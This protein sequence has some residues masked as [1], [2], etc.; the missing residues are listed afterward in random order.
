MVVD[1][2]FDK[3]L[4][5][6]DGHVMR[7]H[8]VTVERKTSKVRLREGSSNVVSVRPRG[9]RATIGIQWSLCIATG[10]LR[11]GC[12]RWYLCLTDSAIG[13]TLN[14]VLFE[15]FLSST[16]NPME[17]S[18][19]RNWMY[20]R[21]DESR[22]ITIQFQ[23]GIERFISFALEHKRISA[24]KLRCPCR[25]CK[26][27]EFHNPD[28]LRVHLCKY[29]FMPDYYCWTS[30]GESHSKH[31]PLVDRHSYYG[32]SGQRHNYDHYEQLV[33]DAAGP[34]LGAHL[35]VYTEE[36]QPLMAEDPNPEASQFFNMLQASQ[37]PLWDGCETHT[38]LSACLTALSL[39]TDYRMTEGC[40]NQWMK[41]VGDVLP[42]GHSMPKD[43][44]NA[45]KSV[46]NLGLGGEK[47]HCCRNGC[48]LFYKEYAQLNTCKFCKEDR[49]TDVM[50]DGKVKAKPLKKMWYFPLVPRLQRLYSSEQTASQMRWHREHERNINSLT[51]P[52]DAEAWL[53]FDEKNNDFAQDPRN[54]RIGLC[55]D[56][57]APF[58][59]TGRTYS[60]W[61][62]IITPYNLPPWMCMRRE[63]LFLSCII[64]GPSNPKRNIDVYLR[65]LIDELKMLWTCGVL[66]YDVSLKQNL[67]MRAA[68]MWTIND[69]PAYGMLSGWQTMGKLACP[70]CMDKCK[71]FSLQ[72]S[73]KVS[74]FDC[75]R[76]FLPL[77]HPYRKNKHAFT[78]GRVE[79]SNIPIR[80]SGE[81]VWQRVRNLM[82][83]EENANFV[84]DEEY[85]QSHH[86]TKRS[87]FWELPYWKDQ[88]LRHNL[89]VMH[90][91]RNVFLNILYTMMDTKGKTKD[92]YNA[93]KD[94]ENH[95]NRSVLH[96]LV[97]PNG[98]VS[99]PKA[100]YT[101]NK[102]QKTELLQ[103][104][105]DLKFPDGYASKMSRCVDMREAKLFG[106]KSHDCHV[107]FQRLLP[108]AFKA[109]PK[110][111]WN[112]LIELGVYFRDICASEL[113]V[114]KLQ[115]MEV[116]VP[117]MLC[118][119]E[120]FFPPSFFDS[121]EHLPIH[122]A[123]EVR[124]GGP[125]QYRWMYPFERFIRTTKQKIGNTNHVEGSIAE[126]YLLEE[127]STFAS[128]YY[129]PEFLTRRTRVPRNDHGCGTTEGA[130][131]QKS[132]F[133]YPG[134]SIGRKSQTTLNSID[135]KTAILYTLLNCSEVVPYLEMFYNLERQQ[136]PLITDTQLDHK[137]T[138]EFPDW[139]SRKIKLNC[140]ALQDVVWSLAWGPSQ[141]VTRYPKYIIN[142]YK[143]A[144]KSS[145]Q[146]MATTNYGVCVRGSQLESLEVDYYGVLIDIIQLDYL[147]Q[148]HTKLLLFKCEWF[149]PSPQ[150]TRKDR[151]GNVEVN[152]S[153]KYN[154][155]DPFIFAQQ[156]EQ[157]YYTT[158]PG[159]QQEWIGV[160]KTKARNIIP[161]TRVKETQSIDEPYQEDAIV[162][163][164][165]HIADDDIHQNLVDTMTEL[166]TIPIHLVDN[167]ETEE[168]EQE[169]LSSPESELDDYE[170]DEENI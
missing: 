49:Y 88:L 81:E 15:L 18:N 79:T 160:I 118:K 27:K 95:C 12:G 8:S 162:D 143:F 39:K 54:V 147:G 152:K 55:S 156:A 63:F 23:Q 50:K 146:G 20:T 46:K 167:D 108:W 9:Y 47:I 130:C 58:E 42:P 70:I 159:R 71:G 166:E 149:D 148:G 61:P 51:H 41:F 131:I 30:H 48:M 21:I 36:N 115:E 83:A 124:V 7:L 76:Q 137:T 126:K 5:L 4:G 109:L 78:K 80:L 106:M 56:G 64:P 101:L 82:S 164:H 150:G 86:M 128:Y 110:H 22:S 77:S 1:L 73:H 59:M 165:V 112:A 140:N 91:E 3:P 103:W 125:V 68:L 10:W 107:F 84:P 13:C 136:N 35:E 24:H 100:Q 52:S 92:T 44:Y 144:T 169:I 75:H 45:K 129:P 31:P 121:M 105:K 2:D 40:F 158:Y 17:G 141:M 135:R 19:D 122:L 161:V 116:S 111:I 168:D 37:R 89:D 155:Y 90:I 6:W 62:V 133:N 153:R 120:M 57:F 145:N 97:Q 96:L 85:G 163:V 67:I 65:P 114:T 87:I 142:G 170:T 123:Y 14:S 139:F 69:F 99:K 38:T 60:C 16:L 32:S 102:E 25:K 72:H 119:L 74:W 43:F 33:M 34:N 113:S 132:I 94:L 26:C 157:V 28:T 127:M 117:I 151:Y 11:T 66:T 134:R 93:R 138:T 53:H 154:R 104:I 98:R 29:G